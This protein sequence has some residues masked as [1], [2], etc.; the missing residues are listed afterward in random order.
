[1]DFNLKFTGILS[2]DIGLELTSYFEFMIG[3]SG[4][5]HHRSCCSYGHW[6]DRSNCNAFNEVY[7]KFSSS[8]KCQQCYPLNVYAHESFD[9]YERPTS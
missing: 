5:F 6:V 9:C 7:P 1:M 4:R 3:N 8:S 2:I